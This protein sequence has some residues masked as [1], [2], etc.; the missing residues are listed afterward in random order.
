MSWQLPLAGLG[1]AREGGPPARAPLAPA[2]ARERVC[3]AMI[4]HD[5]ERRWRRCGIVD[6][7]DDDRCERCASG[8]AWYL[9]ARS[10]G[11]YGE[12]PGGA[13]RGGGAE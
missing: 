10:I 3:L 2:P 4:W 12:P 11:R 5:G 1:E 13:A 7:N 8:V 9:D 6:A